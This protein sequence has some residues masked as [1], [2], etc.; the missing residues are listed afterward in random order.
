MAA[1]SIPGPMPSSTLSDATSPRSASSRTTC[2][3]RTGESAWHR[4]DDSYFERSAFSFELHASGAED[5]PTAHQSSAARL[6]GLCDSW[7]GLSQPDAV[8]QASQWSWR[9]PVPLAH[10]RHQGGDQERSDD[11]RVDRDGERSAE[12]ELFGEEQG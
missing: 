1:A 5:P 4:T 7:G 10:Q 6:L 8:V 2:A 9:P 12:T 3:A 11:A